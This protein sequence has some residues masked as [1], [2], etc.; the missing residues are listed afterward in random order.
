MDAFSK[1]NEK[2]VSTAETRSFIVTEISQNSDESQNS[3]S[4]CEIAP[5]T[6]TEEAKLNNTFVLQKLR[7]NWNR[8]N[9]S[10]KFWHVVKSELPGTLAYTKNDAAR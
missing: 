3:S 5:G 9:D 2:E 10:L 4:D 7:K 8:D 1:G 6:L